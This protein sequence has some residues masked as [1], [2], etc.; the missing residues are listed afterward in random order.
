MRDEDRIDPTT[1]ATKPKVWKGVLKP[2]ELP[3]VADLVASPEGELRYEVSGFL[4]KQ[5]RKLV[6]CIIKGFAQLTCRV[7]MEDFRY[8]IDVEDRLVLVD[9]ESALP[10]IEMESEEE[11]FVVAEVP[12]DVR[13]LVEDAVILALPM[14][15]R[16]PGIE[17]VP[18]VDD[19]P[20]RESPF[21]ALKR[22]K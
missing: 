20:P 8:D 17:E 21:A 5:R 13:N 16:K 14:I 3:R 19:K 7:S 11:D 22:P 2:G 1:F 18:K 4:D 15:P 6:S 10:P 12:L 9:D